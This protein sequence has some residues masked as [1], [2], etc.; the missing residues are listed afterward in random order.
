MIR[1]LTLPAGFILDLLMGDPR[2]LYHPVCLIGNLI[3]ILEKGIRKVFP[4]TDKSERAGGILEVVLV[5]FITFFIP[6]GVIHLFYKWNFWLGF[7]LETFWCGQLLA[8]KSLK[9]E[10]MKVYDRL[11]NGTIEEARYAVSMI[12]GRDTQ[13]LSEIGVTKAAVETVAENPS[14]GIIA[15]MFYMAIGGIPLMFLY[16][17]INTM[18]SMLGYKNDKYLYFG[19]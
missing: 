11:K 7:A 3:S 6:Y 9:V 2:W 12:V 4:K 16:K 13:A 1:L 14:D 18:D 17:G 15:P 10:S 19:R 5:C 8:T